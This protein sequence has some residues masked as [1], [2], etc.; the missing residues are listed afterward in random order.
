M[1][2]VIRKSLS[3]EITL[4]LMIIVVLCSV[5]FTVVEEN[6]ASYVDALWYS[7]AVITTIGFGDVSVTTTLGRILSVILG[8]S[9]IAVVALFTSFIVN[10]YNEMSKRRE[11]RILNKLI[12]ESNQLEKAEEK[13]EIEKEKVDK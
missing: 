4:V 7:F 11:E 9:G 5:Y 13:L 10:F 6:I 2:N 3:K 8:I 1:R 12:K